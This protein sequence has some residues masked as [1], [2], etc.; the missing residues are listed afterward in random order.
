MN[1]LLKY[2]NI[3]A[4][5]DNMIVVNKTHM[6]V[7]NLSDVITLSISIEL[8]K[9]IHERSHARG[10]IQDTIYKLAKWNFSCRENKTSQCSRKQ[11]KLSNQ[12]CNILFCV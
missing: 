7:D 8:P 11:K 5:N 9:I 1:K 12:D 6:I 3:T 10:K 2:Y 4:N